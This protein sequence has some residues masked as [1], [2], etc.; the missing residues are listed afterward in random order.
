MGRGKTVK[1]IVEINSVLVGSTGKIAVQLAELAE[2]QGDRVMVCV[3]RGR[4]NRHRDTSYML[5]LFGS[6]LSEDGHLI[7][8]RLTGYNGC[9][10]RIATKRLLRRIDEFGPD[11]IHLHNLHNSYI[12]LPLLFKYVKEKN[13]PVVWT[14]H[15]CWSFTGQCPH[16]VLAGCDKWRTGCHD[17]PQYRQYPA[18]YVDR[19]R[20][21]WKKKKDWFTGVPNLTIV[22]PSCWLGDLA[23]QS[24]LGSYPIRVIHNGI[25]LSVFR[26]TESDFRVK[27]GL[28]GKHIVLG[29]AFGWGRKKGLDVL[30]ELSQRLGDDYKVVLVGT[31]DATDERLPKNILSIHRTNNQRELAEIYSAADVLAQP[32]REENYPTVN[33]E[34][35]A[36]GTPV[37][38][39]RT[40]GS[41]EMLD[42]TCG[43]VVDCDDVDAMES[44]I[45]RACEEKPYTKEA[46][47]FKARGFASDDRFEEYMKLY[48]E[49]TE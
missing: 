9:F 3:P 29:V 44:A 30:I 13:I 48:K 33:M 38:T 23:R 49:I 40:G 18:A 4:H 31:N 45:R 36:C 16:F 32:T 28:E 15:D 27:N 10:S 7:L 34:A 11:V 25:D 37:V 8:G 17:C 19:T 21:M 43:A 39:F 47:L 12:N 2:R 26:P 5:C 24:Y 14:L 20:T 35:I 1:K 41:P 46:C 42:A 22:T 6:R